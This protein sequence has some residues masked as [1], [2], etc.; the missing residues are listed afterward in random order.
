M[1]L[2]F[3]PA[4]CSLTGPLIWLW[5]A[6]LY[7]VCGCGYAWPPL[8]GH[9]SIYTTALWGLAVLMGT[10]SK[11]SPSSNYKTKTCLMCGEVVIMVQVGESL[12][13]MNE[14]ICNLH[15]IYAMA[16]KGTKS[17][18]VCHGSQRWGWR[19]DFGKQKNVSIIP[20][21]HRAQ[22]H[23]KILFTRLSSHRDVKDASATPARIQWRDMFCRSIQLQRNPLVGFLEVCIEENNGP[24]WII[25][26]Q[27]CFSLTNTNCSLRASR[28]HKGLQHQQQLQKHPLLQP[29]EKLQIPRDVLLPNKSALNVCLR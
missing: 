14:N 27:W 25:S 6:D 1:T 11:K 24:V 10:Q 28:R 9:K 16:W 13:E 7:W 8:W 15:R 17:D 2:A 19:C 23:G 26:C 4:L 20:Q 21:L 5:P 22:D 3:S 18:S 29:H 12:Q